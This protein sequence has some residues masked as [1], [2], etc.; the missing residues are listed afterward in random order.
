MILTNEFQLTKRVITMATKI[1]CDVCDKEKK[2]VMN[3][4]VTDGRDPHHGRAD[5]KV[6]DICTS[7]TMLLCKRTSGLLKINN[8]VSGLKKIVGV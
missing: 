7:C 1:F 5:V 8:S 2:E 4:E 6:I 3:L